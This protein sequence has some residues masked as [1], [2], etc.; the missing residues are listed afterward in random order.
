MRSDVA[1]ARINGLIF[2]SLAYLACDPSEFID[3]A[4]YFERHGADLISLAEAIDT[5]TPEGKSFFTIV[6][7]LASWARRGDRAK[8][9]PS[10]SGVRRSFRGGVTPFGYRRDGDNLRLDENEAPIRRLIFELFLEH[11]KLKTVARLLNARQ[12]RT[13]KGKEFTDTSVRRLIEDPLAKGLR[14]SNYTASTG[15]GKHWLLKPSD[16]WVYSEAPAIV[17]AEVWDTANA[18]LSARK[19]RDP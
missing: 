8:G 2:A 16:E 6:I 19:V 14:R 15:D 3:L 13:R 1:S 9:P 18:I 4:S 12:L 7:N 10:N 5:S 11:R 17:S